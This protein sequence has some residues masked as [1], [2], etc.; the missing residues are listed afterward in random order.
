MKAKVDESKVVE[1]FIHYRMTA[2]KSYKLEVG[3]WGSKFMSRSIGKKPPPR[4]NT[5]PALFEGSRD[6]IPEKSFQ[7]A[8]RPKVA[9]CILEG[10]LITAAG[11]VFCT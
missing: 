3:V 10:P 7:E 6:P 5:T 11:V 4:R 9:S 2:A 1:A 8:S